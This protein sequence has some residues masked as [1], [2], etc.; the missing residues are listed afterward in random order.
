MRDGRAPVAWRASRL[1]LRNFF[2]Q[3]RR[4]RPFMTVL[5]LYQR[6]GLGALAQALPG[7]LQSLAQMVPLVSPRPYDARG[8]VAAPLD[9]SPTLRV[10]LLAGCV[11]PY[12]FANVH[13]ATVRVLARQGCRV[14]V[15][16][17]QVCC[18]ALHLHAGDRQEARRLARRNID[19]F[20]AEDVDA[21]VIDAGGCGAALKEYGELL[22]DDP[23]YAEKARRFSSLVREV[24]ELLAELP[25]AD[26]LG[27]LPM[28]VTY[29]DPCHLAHAQGIK[30]QPR[31]LLRAIPG[32]EL[33]E[34]AQP[35]V[36]CGSAGLYS[37]F[38]PDMSR[39]LLRRKMHDVASTGASVIATANP[40]C[41]LQLEAGLRLHGLPGRVV[42]VIEL[43]DEAYRNGRRA[44]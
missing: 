37:V 42:H 41:H 14:T 21:I 28:A 23:R 25:L 34:M 3:P 9:G 38:H 33:R 31:A 17:G 2:S 6:S 12:L 1:L 18:G 30:A 10:A 7:P 35:D 11:M 22:K 39:R 8:L 13:R 16:E 19:A 5:G 15:P 32:L 36:C 24:T 40:G 29:Q 43:L 20:L 44:V 4:L 27:A 26:G